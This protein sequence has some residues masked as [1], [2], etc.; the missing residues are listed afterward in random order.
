M[1]GHHVISSSSELGELSALVHRQ[2]I[3]FLVTLVAFAQHVA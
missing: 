2:V 3:V 1:P